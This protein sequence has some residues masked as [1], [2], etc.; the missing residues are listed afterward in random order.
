MRTARPNPEEK[1]QGTLEQIHER[2]PDISRRLTFC[3]LD[4]RFAC[5][6]VFQD[7]MN[8]PGIRNSDMNRIIDNEEEKFSKEDQIMQYQSFNPSYVPRKSRRRD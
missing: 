5:L 6:G 2:F 8:V 1:F 7:M 4:V 3:S